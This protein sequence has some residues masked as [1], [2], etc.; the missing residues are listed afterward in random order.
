MKFTIS[1]RDKFVVIT[2][3]YSKP[4]E[5]RLLYDLTPPD[6]VALDFA[7]KGVILS[8]EG[9][10]WLYAFLTHYYHPVK[11]VAVH[12]PRLKG[13]VVVESHDAKYRAGMIIKFQTKATI[14]RARNGRT[15]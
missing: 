2:F 5:P 6:P 12:V 10:I 7:D 3:S 1:Y 9:P 8:G 14:P 13:A 4:V 11:F 15:K